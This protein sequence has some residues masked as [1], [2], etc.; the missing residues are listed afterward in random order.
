MLNR[1]LLTSEVLRSMR[2][3]A[4]SVL[5]RS[6]PHAVD[7][8]VNNA[9]VKVLEGISTFDATRGDFKGWASVIA[10]NEARNYSKRKHNHGHDSETAFDDHGEAVALTETLIGDDGRMEATRSEESQ[11]LAMALATLSAEERAFILAIND[12]M[13]QTE[14]GALVGWSPATAT[15]RRKA[16]AAKLAALR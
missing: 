16:I 2:G 14:A 8:C 4:G 1:T 13:G 7:D 15:R 10:R 6:M 5:G 11:W 9:V 12:G 3:A